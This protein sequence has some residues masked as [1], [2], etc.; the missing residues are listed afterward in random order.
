MKILRAILSGLVIWAL[1]FVEW[2]IMIFAPVLKDLGNWQYLI[3]YVVLIPIVLF[4]AS[5]Y[6]KSGDKVNGL[7]LGLIMLVTGIILDAIITV[8][9]FTSPQGVGY[10]KFFINPLMLIG[11]VEFMVITS[12]Y[13]TKK[14][15]QK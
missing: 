1:I 3:H 6:Y 5:Y 15:K 11:F 12:L 14:I 4:G 7:V 2:S 9:F 13:W 8:P 10:V